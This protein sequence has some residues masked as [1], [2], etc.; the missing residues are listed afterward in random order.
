MCAKSRK[1]QWLRW[2]ALA[3][4]SVGLYVFI[5]DRYRLGDPLDVFNTDQLCVALPIAIVFGI[6][7]YKMRWDGVKRKMAWVE[8]PHGDGDSAGMSAPGCQPSR[9]RTVAAQPSESAPEANSPFEDPQPAVPFVSAYATTSGLSPEE[10]WE[11]ARS[12]PHNFIPDPSVDGT[13]VALVYH[14][15]RGGHAD[16]LAKL[17]DYAVRRG[18]KVEAY[19]WA[20]VAQKRGHTGMETKM[21]RIRK[22]WM[23]E[24]ASGEY[25]NVYDLFSESCGTVGRSLL[26]IACGVDAP[27]A[28]KRL[29]DLA[30][31]G[32]PYAALFV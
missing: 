1:A 14:A 31:K 19:F 21:I 22:E 18:A 7:A 20:A 26:R 2:L 8:E 12:T 16:A 23:L 4:V 30:E 27:H 15:A 13:Y 25:D 32:D 11:K 9:F 29:H 3:A 6:L 10:A 5:V 24:G 28:R 17:S